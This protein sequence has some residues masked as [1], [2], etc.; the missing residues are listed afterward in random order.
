MVTLDWDAVPSATGYTVYWGTN[1]GVTPVTGTPVTVA[2]PP[3]RHEG[4]VNGTT[5]YYVATATNPT[6]EGPPS[7]EVFATPRQQRV[8]TVTP[9]EPIPDNGQDPGTTC[10][11]PQGAV[12]TVIVGVVDYVETDAGRVYDH[13]APQEALR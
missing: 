5:H 12:K 3:W 7:G 2:S 6:A 13:R 10:G 8:Y 11:D 9:A 4:L 1:P